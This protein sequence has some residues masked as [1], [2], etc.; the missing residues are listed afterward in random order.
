MFILCSK[1]RRSWRLWKQSISASAW[2]F[3]KE[4][5]AKTRR[6]SKTLQ[7]YEETG[8]VKL[9]NYEDL[10]LVKMCKSLKVSLLVLLLFAAVV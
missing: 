8:Q 7:L 9:M 4:R 2:C 3:L 10:C 5:L 1:K 6:Q